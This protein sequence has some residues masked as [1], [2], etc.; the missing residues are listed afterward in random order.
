MTDQTLK[1]PATPTDRLG[2]YS[3]AVFC[4]ALAI[5]SLV[6]WAWWN[7]A[8]HPDPDVLEYVTIARNLLLHGVFG[9]VSGVSD[10]N[11]PPLYPALIATLWHGSGPPFIALCVVQAIAGAV[12]VMLGF[13]IASRHWG[14][15]VTWLATAGI[16]LSPLSCRFAVNPETETVFTSLLVAGL[17]AWGERRPRIAGLFFGL[18]ALTHSILVPYVFG[19]AV[20][21]FLPVWKARRRNHLII[22]TTF[23]ITVIPWAARNVIQL[24]RATLIA[25]SGWRSNLLYGTLDLNLFVGNVWS[26]VLKLPA[27]QVNT[28]D[29]AVAEK[30]LLDRAV[31]RIAA[32]P[33]HWL[34]VRLKQ[35]PRLFADSG[36]YIDLHNRV[37]NRIRQFV[38]YAGDLS[39]VGLS[40]FACFRLRRELAATVHIWS[41]PLFLMVSHLPMW[42]EV[43]RLV[44]AIP[45]LTILSAVAIEIILRRGVTRTTARQTRQSLAL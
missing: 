18:A 24:H 36:E 26:I 28:T 10:S 9:A 35:Y 45:E 12:T 7:R 29:A 1:L 16:A 23:L 39:L 17:W 5:R 14:I 11:R 38:F 43:R 27:T 32:D 13:R 8:L 4:T 25:D 33:A 37:T 21:G 3:A 44:P 31:A 20:L 2:R 6:L 42:V 30:V 41:F 34:F 19:I 15:R 22:L 40:I